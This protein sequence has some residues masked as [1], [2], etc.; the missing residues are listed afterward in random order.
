MSQSTYPTWECGLRGLN[1]TLT[2]L[3]VMI[4]IMNHR[5]LYNTIHNLLKTKHNNSIVQYILT[6]TEKE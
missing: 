6:I 3:C 4:V 2:I 1:V 5:D